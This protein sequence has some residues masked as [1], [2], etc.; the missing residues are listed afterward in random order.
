MAAAK[1]AK[2]RHNKKLSMIH[3]KMNKGPNHTLIGEDYNIFMR[4]KQNFLSV[5]GGANFADMYAATTFL[6]GSK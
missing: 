2:V 1:I 5:G 4:H 6:N 3:I